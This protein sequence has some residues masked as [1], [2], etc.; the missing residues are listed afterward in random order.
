MGGATAL[1]STTAMEPATSVEPAAASMQAGARAAAKTES[2]ARGGRHD[3]NRRG[4]Q[5]SGARNGAHARLAEFSGI[6]R[7]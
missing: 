7:G 5:T 4:G 1:E 6:R 3:E 2:V